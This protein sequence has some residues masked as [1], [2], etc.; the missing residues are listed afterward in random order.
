MQRDVNPADVVS[1]D[2]QVIRFRSLPTNFF[3]SSFNEDIP[4][5]SFGAMLVLYLLG[6]DCT[7]LHQYIVDYLQLNL[8]DGGRWEFVRPDLLP[9]PLPIA[10]T[11]WA[12]ECLTKQKKESSSFDDLLPQLIAL[13]PSLCVLC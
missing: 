7:T 2:A 3:H 13:D 9:L 10:V 4:F 1:N 12:T 8:G 5:S 11:D 6:T